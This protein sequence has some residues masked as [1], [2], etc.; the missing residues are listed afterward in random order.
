MPKVSRHRNYSKSY[1][2]P[3]RPYEK[4]RIDHEMKLIGEYGLRCKREIWRSQLVLAKCRSTARELL[5]L[6]PKD[7]RRMFE[8]SALLR[9][10]VRYGLLGDD[11]KNLDSVL[12]LQTER[13]LERRLQTK[14]FKQRLARSIHEARV[15][16]KQ[17]HIRVGKQVVNVPSFLVRM[18]SEGHIDL[19]S[20]SPY[21]AT[22][23]KGRVARRNAANKGGGDED[24]E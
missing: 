6:D 5:T 14:V 18:E 19:A 21:S 10:L 9:R 2:T 7:P 20:T 1:K 22:G 8:G 13:L 24:D 12:T 17:R 4:E 3:R 11:E 15:M 16:I 23:R